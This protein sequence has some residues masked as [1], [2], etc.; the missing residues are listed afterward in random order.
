LTVVVGRAVS[1][2]VIASIGQRA[3]AG[4]RSESRANS[5]VVVS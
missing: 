2:N 4:S 5:T 1:G 3:P